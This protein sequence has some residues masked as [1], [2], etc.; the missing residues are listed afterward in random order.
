LRACIFDNNYI[1]SFC[2]LNY[3]YRPSLWNRDG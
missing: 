2:Y 1:A 3:A